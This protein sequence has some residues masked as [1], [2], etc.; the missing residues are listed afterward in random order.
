M[1]GMLTAVS[2]VPCTLIVSWQILEWILLSLLECL[3]MFSLYL[4]KICFPLWLHIVIPDLQESSS[5]I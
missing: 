1:L 5:H 3:E 4:M 2:S